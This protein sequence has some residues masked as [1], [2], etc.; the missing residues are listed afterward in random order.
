MREGIGTR[1][2]VL[3]GLAMALAFTIVSSAAAHP[4]RLI[5]PRP[6]MGWNSWDAYGFTLDEAQ[7]KANASVLE[8]LKRFGWRYAV[9][10]EGWYMR[11]PFGSDLKTREYQIDGQGRLIPDVKRFPSAADGR[12][13][14]ALADWAHARGLK[15]GLHIVRGVPKQAVEENLPIAN[16]PYRM[17]DAAD[18]NAT[19]PWDDANYGVADNA[20]GQAYYNSII[21]MYAAWGVDFLKVDCISDHPYR[22][23]EIRQLATAIRNAGRPIV[24]SLSPGP[25]QL[26]HA[27]EVRHD[28]QMW[29]IAND[30]WDGWSFKRARPQDDFPNGIRPF[31]DYLAAWNRWSGSGH[32]PDADML[33]VGS[34][35]P[36]PGWG[37][38]RQSRLTPDEAK[39]LFSLWAISRSPM[40][41]GANLTELDARTR[42]LATNAD[43]IALDQRAGVGRPSDV[44]GLNPDRARVWVSTP[45]GAKHPDTVAVFNLSD[46]PLAVKVRWTALGL[47]AGHLRLRDLWSGAQLRPSTRADLIVPPHG[48]AALRME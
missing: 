14:K 38:P 21:K 25:T 27:R 33:P 29:R 23:T 3:A 5:A 41:F 18:R 4:G 37:A 46:Q 30:L 45:Q 6:P 40:I 1:L 15:F 8:T 48:V 22:P 13:F 32:W 43:I 31:F 11:N 17:A 34:I 44:P 47:P 26:S 39:T 24:L 28:A 7:F 20:A 12:G 10:D 35:R 36:H 42:A 19:C 9:I 16:S 2:R